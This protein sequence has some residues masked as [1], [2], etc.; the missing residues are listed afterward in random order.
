MKV[1]GRTGSESYCS[2]LVEI[3]VGEMRQITATDPHRIPVG[4][5]IDVD[6]IFNSVKLILAAEAQTAAYANT[7]HALA[8]T[9]G[10]LAKRVG[11]AVQLPPPPAAKIDRGDTDSGAM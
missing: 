1:L 4:C 8:N 6:K 10:D 7:L 2:F 3:S 9:I 5:S 11:E